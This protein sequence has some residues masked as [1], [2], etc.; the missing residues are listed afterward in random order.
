MPHRD[1]DAARAERERLI[2]PETFT[3]GGQDFTC[4][5]A[6]ALGDVFDLADA[7]EPGDDLMAASRAMAFFVE[8]LL[9]PEDRPRWHDILRALDTPHGPINAYDVLEVGMYLSEVFTG[10][11]TE[12]STDSSGGRASTGDN[13]TRSTTNGPEADTSATSG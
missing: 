4:V 3:F 6:P 7:P 13:S 10:R 1:F 2:E 12:P 9:V 8:K 5:L 11:P